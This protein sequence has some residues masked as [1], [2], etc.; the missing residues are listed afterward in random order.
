M[1]TLERAFRIEF[2]ENE[3]ETLVYSLHAHYKQGLAM[4]DTDSGAVM[5]DIKAL[6][7]DLASLIN[8]SFM[9]ADA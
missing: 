1:K 8:K 4:G 3:I 9:G 5:R 7:N 2:T 6:R